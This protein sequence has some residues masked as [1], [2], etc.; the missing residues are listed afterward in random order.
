MSISADILEEVRLFVNSVVLGAVLTF[1]YDGWL[2]LRKVFKHNTFWISLE[3][4]IFW[5]FTFAVVF[6][7][8]RE[9]NNGVLRWFV[10]VGA[11]IG[12]LLYK[13]SLSKFYVNLIGACLLHIVVYIKKM[14]YFVF[15]PLILVKK[16]IKTGILGAKKGSKKVTIT[17]KNKLTDCIK[18]FTIAL[19]KHKSKDGD[20]HKENEL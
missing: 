20:L 17:L 10:I 9:Q 8:L 15:K 18:W 16:G 11:G 12:M 6:N 5:I 3:D 13:G 19:C 7:S 2:I 4:F 1:F 14:A